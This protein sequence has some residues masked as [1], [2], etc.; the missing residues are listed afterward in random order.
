MDSWLVFLPP[1]SRSRYS[2]TH[3]TNFHFP[4]GVEVGQA[5]LNSLQRVRRWAKHFKVA[6]MV[7][8][9]YQNWRSKK[10]S[11]AGKVETSSGVLHTRMTLQEQVQYVRHVF[12]EYLCYAGL[13]P[14][15]LQGK[16]ILEVGPGETFGVALQFL[17][18]GARQVVCVDKFFPKRNS[19]REETLYATLGTTLGEKH[20]ELVDTV[21][22]TARKVR[23]AIPP[24]P[25]DPL[26]P[27]YGVSLSAADRWLDRASFDLIVSRSVLEHLDQLEQGFAV[28]DHLLKPGGQMLHIID[29]RDHGMF[30]ESGFHP[31]TLLTI[32]EVLYR[33]MTVHS[34]KPN[35]R[36]LSHYRQLM[37]TYRYATQILVTRVV[38]RQTPLT[39]YKESLT[40]GVDYTDAEL[41]LLQQIRPKLRGPYRCLPDEELLVA[42][43]WLSAR[44]PD[45]TR[46]VDLPF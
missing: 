20:K 42:G 26:Y 2:R 19:A 39:P 28:M 29:F 30:T 15:Q 27:L 31:L 25:S 5:P 14:D 40:F 8:A 16:R 43:I 41:T 17:A 10:Q 21:R 22:E 13:A 33:A 37:A 6:I 38:G 35:R 44:K 24:I 34:G 23:A 46:R 36:L 32:P 45:Y 11:H 18:A 7:Y 1:M 9:L 4:S 12:D 3:K